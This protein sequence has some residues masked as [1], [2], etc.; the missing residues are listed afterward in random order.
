MIRRGRWYWKLSSKVHFMQSVIDG[1]PNRIIID[2]QLRP[3]QPTELQRMDVRLPLIP[4][5]DMRPLEA[6]ACPPQISA[7]CLQ[8]NTW[9][10][11]DLDSIKAPIFEKDAIEKLLLPTKD[12]LLAAISQFQPPEYAASDATLILLHGD[13]GVGKTT[14]ARHSAASTRDLS[15]RHNRS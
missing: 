5:G 7:Y 8:S 3:F 4:T 15:R 6:L 11:P 1:N 14:A 9:S 13:H 10:E 2:Q 12:M